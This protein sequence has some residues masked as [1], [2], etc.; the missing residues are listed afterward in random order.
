VDREP[1]QAAWQFDCPEQGLIVA[2][3]LAIVREVCSAVTV[4]YLGRVAEQ[5]NSR[6]LFADPAHPYSQALL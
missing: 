2:H 6:A 4:M 5:G 1:V 3:D